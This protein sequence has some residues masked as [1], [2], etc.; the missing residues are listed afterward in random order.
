[1]STAGKVL[2]VLI[3]LSAI[4]CL[5]L[6]GGVA[7]VNYNANQKLDQLAKEL[8]KTR[9]SI[10]ATKLDIM[11]TRDQTTVVQEQV[12][13]DFSR[14]ESQQTDLERTRTQILDTLT[15]LQYD[16]GTVNSTIAQ[17]KDSLQH[18]VNEFD[19]ET[20][21]MADLRRDV[22]SRRSDNTQLMSRL[23]SLKDQFGKTQRENAEMLG[24]RR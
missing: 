8:E 14:L 15:R 3:M 18:R 11:N 19:A 12:D 17:A 20:K 1:M 22:Q 7:Q 10:E 5:I 16:L 24:K 13:R 2:V 23:Q 21:A 9:E 6:A 4:A